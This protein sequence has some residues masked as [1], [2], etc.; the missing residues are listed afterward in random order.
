MGLRFSSRLRRAF[1]EF[2]DKRK[3]QENVQPEKSSAEK[4]Q[5]FRDKVQKD[6]EALMM[7]QDNSN[8][9]DV[10]GMDEV[11]VDYGQ[12]N[13]AQGIFENDEEDK[14]KRALKGFGRRN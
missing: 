6:T 4:E 9:I 7:N 8:E 11:S 1:R 10:S 13:V 12:T 14:L 2:M 5:E 3:A